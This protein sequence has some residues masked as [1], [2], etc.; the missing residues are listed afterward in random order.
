[1]KQKEIIRIAENAG[2]P[3]STIDKDWVLGHVLNSMFSFEDIQKNFIFKGGTCLRKC[4]FENY[5]FSED[6]DFTLLD[7]NYMVDGIFMEKILK[8]AQLKSDVK[9]NLTPQIKSQIHNDVEQGYE[10]E[11]HFWGANHKPNQK[12]LP[13]N[14]WLTSIK[15]DIS[16]SEKLVCEPKIRKLHH[17]YPDIKQVNQHITC[18]HLDEIIAEKVRSLAQRNRP[19]DIFDNWFFSNVIEEKDFSAIKKILI[20]KAENKSVDISKI[21]NLVNQQKYTVNKR[22]WYNSLQHQIAKAELPDFDEAYKKVHWFVENILN[23]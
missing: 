20:K 13:K 5:R 16:F 10:I 8:T 15:I 19:R 1:M 2:V 11:I 12:P 14:R 23:S 18:Y 21:E 4:Y 22:A 9:F 6:L 3:P 17:Y 7:K